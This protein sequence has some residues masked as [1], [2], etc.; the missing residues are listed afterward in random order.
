MDCISP[1]ACG[2]PAFPNH[3]TLFKAG[4]LLVENLRNLNAMAGQTCTFFALPL[5]LPDADGAP[6][7]A[8]AIPD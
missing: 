7:R 4:F 3:L 5:L 8:T 2:N 1:D 6:C